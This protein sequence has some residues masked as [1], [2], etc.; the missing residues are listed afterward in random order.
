MSTPYDALFTP[1]ED[2]EPDVH[3]VDLALRMARESLDRCA[4]KNIHSDGQ[5]LAAAV[6]LEFTLRQLVTAL[7]AERGEGR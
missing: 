4:P 7:D 3:S 1:G 2:L 6:D 5:M